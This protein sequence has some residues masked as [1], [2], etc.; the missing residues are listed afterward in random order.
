MAIDAT[1]SSIISE[2]QLSNL[3]FSLQITPFTAYITLK[4]SVIRDQN[5]VQ[6]VPSPP[7]LVLLQQAHQSVAQ[8]REENE[9]LKLNSDT[10]EMKKENLVKDNEAMVESLAVYSNNLAVSNASNNALRAKLEAAEKQ[11]AKLSSAKNSSEANLKTTKKSHQQEMNHANS[12][13]KS[14]EK[15][16]KGLEK[17]IHNLKR[18]LESTREK[19]K[20]LKTEHS[21]LK[22]NK[23][24]L[25]T[26][27]K[28]LEKVVSKKGSNVTKLLKKDV[29]KNDVKLND[30][31]MC[32]SPSSL[33]FS[34]SKS[35]PAQTPS[36]PPFTSMLPH[37]NPLP[38][39][40]PYMPDSTT[41]VAHSIRFSS[42]LCCPMNS[43]D[44]SSPN[45]DD[46][47][48]YKLGNMIDKADF[49]EFIA[50]FREQLRADRAKILSE[51]KLDF[52]W[53]KEK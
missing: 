30:S 34:S 6:A 22:I 50:E 35:L 51:I 41:M 8:L 7:I 44:S 38:A 4:K 14:L 24:K 18:I 37:W 19:L 28:K 1:F 9:Q 53:C 10:A 42:P 20:T 31:E 27:I 2:I 46:S 48:E 26:E 16:G 47:E 3:N 39:T 45:D 13:I 32:S 29:N 23:T 12:V 11:I 49:E 33:F 15:D 40:P 36:S 5:G 52:G 17:E 43:V 25:E 21:S